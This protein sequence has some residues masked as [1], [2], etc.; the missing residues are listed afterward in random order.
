MG[1]EAPVALYRFDRFVLDLSRGA[2]LADGA[3]CPLRPKCFALLR[4]LVENAGRLIGRDELMQAVWPGVFVTDDSIAQCVKDIRRALGDDEQ[5][6][7]RT[8]P[9][10]GYLFA[11]SVARADAAGGIVPTTAMSAAA[12][13]EA[14]PRPPTKRPV[15]V[16]VPFENI[17]GDPAQGY[18]ADGLTAGLGTDLA[19]FQSLH[20]VSLLRWRGGS[21]RALPDEDAALPP[22]TRFLVNGSVRRAGGR[23][24]VIAQLEDAQRGVT[25]WAERFDRPIDDLFAVQEELVNRIVATLA[26]RVNHELV[27]SAKRRPPASLDAY[28][29]CLRGREQYRQFT[30][31]TTL[32]AREMFDRAITADP[33]YSLAF[34]LQS[35]T[36]QR[37]FT[38]GWGE[39]RGP[40]AL[41]LALTLGRRAVALDP[42]SSLCLASLACVLMLHEGRGSEALKTGRDAVDANSLDFWTRA[43]YGVILTHVGEPEAGAR[44]A[45]LAL[46]LNPLHSPTVRASLGRALL[47]GGHPAE[48]LPELRWCA[49]RLPDY[50]HCHMSLVVACVETGLMEEARAAL[51]EVHRLYPGWRPRNFDALWFFHRQADAQR[52]MTAFRAAGSPEGLT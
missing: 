33:D 46:S 39:P 50:G 16:V 41:D 34:A 14:P 20:V 45:R 15:V 52:F 25:L 12:P 3:E 4:H 28:D 37:G 27:Q 47:L 21:R 30:E 5:R 13:A 22:R 9:R 48:A 24:R 44:E 10:R 11:A 23:I 26:D 36:V 49:S 42:T 31:A 51:R 7:L 32:V 8:L 38:D 29:L 18:F 35:L 43:I 2:L 6:L 19:R 40:T 17:G 1:S